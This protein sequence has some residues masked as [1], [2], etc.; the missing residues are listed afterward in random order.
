MQS[1]GSQFSS[2]LNYLWGNSNGPSQTTTPH[3]SDEIHSDDS[4]DSQ[5]LDPSLIQA[6][7]A[8][9]AEMEKKLEESRTVFTEKVLKLLATEK[10]LEKAMDIIDRLPTDAIRLLNLNAIIP[11]GEFGGMSILWVAADYSAINASERILNL[12]KC[13]PKEQIYKLDFNAGGKG[14]WSRVTVCS[15]I[16]TLGRVK[17]EIMMEIFHLISKEQFENLLFTC[18]LKSTVNSITTYHSVIVMLFTAI[19]ESEEF[20]EFISML[21][22]RQWGLIAG[23]SMDPSIPDDEVNLLTKC[24]AQPE[25]YGWW[26]FAEYL[27][28]NNTTKEELRALPIDRLLQELITIKDTFSQ[29]CLG[30]FLR[31]RF[32][33]FFENSALKSE[34][35]QHFGTRSFPPRIAQRI[36]DQFVQETLAGNKLIA[37][38]KVK[39]QYLILEDEKIDLFNVLRGSLKNHGWLLQYP[40]SPKYMKFEAKNDVSF[41]NLCEFMDL[42]YARLKGLAAVK[43]S[44][45][46]TLPAPMESKSKPAEESILQAPERITPSRS[47]HQKKITSQSTQSPAKKPRPANSAKKQTPKKP[48]LRQTTSHVSQAPFEKGHASDDRHV[49]EELPPFPPL[50]KTT[51]KARELEYRVQ[52]SA[53]GEIEHKANFSE[54]ESKRKLLGDFIE[55]RKNGKKDDIIKYLQENEVYQA[56][57]L[58]LFDLICKINRDLQDVEGMLSLDGDLIHGAYRALRLTEPK[59]SGAAHYSELSIFAKSCYLNEHFDPS[60]LKL[61]ASKHAF[62]TMAKKGIELRCDPSVRVNAIKQLLYSIKGFIK[63]L[64]KPEFSLLAKHAISAS[65][66]LIGEQYKELK[67]DKADGDIPKSCRKILFQFKSYRNFRHGADDELET[68]EYEDEEGPHMGLIN[69]GDD[70]DNL[71]PVL[72]ETLEND[73]ETLQKYFH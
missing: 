15:W 3:D 22:A 24:L 12:L 65:I 17:P 66:I 18:Q 58:A 53:K 55:F 64:D 47:H 44:A 29:E 69:L 50:D 41:I 36:L 5:D 67:G 62:Y 6:D 61:Q 42:T 57:D 63:L 45:A 72:M 13:L 14:A 28:K 23:L 9:K 71:L 35:L 70:W 52:D 39:G 7:L 59:A 19:F 51:V 25:C 16:C 2:L 68:I 30:Y 60:L 1:I 8:R 43:S 20:N 73:V 11:S 32:S 40:G 38:K 31:H 37:I 27:A 56:I 10:N 46:S 49:P 48:R 21:T 54:L 26:T 33:D 34:W 4:D